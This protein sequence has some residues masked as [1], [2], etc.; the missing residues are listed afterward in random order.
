MLAAEIRLPPAFS[1]LNEGVA[2]SQPVV[3]RGT[4]IQVQGPVEDSPLG[5]GA[6]RRSN[7]GVLVKLFQC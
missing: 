1:L 7:R 5:E 2:I 4:V 3:A 6:D